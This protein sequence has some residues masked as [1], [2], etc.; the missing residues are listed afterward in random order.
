MNQNEVTSSPQAG[1]D[2]ILSP[3]QRLAQS[4]QRL[5]NRLGEIS[6]AV[7]REVE[8]AQSVRDGFVAVL[9]VAGLLLTARQVSKSISRKRKKR[10]KKKR[11]S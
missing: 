8:M 10:G 9:G 6:T 3:E 4:R 2:N 11:K 5:Q 1:Q 7:D